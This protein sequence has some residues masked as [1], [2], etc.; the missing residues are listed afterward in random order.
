MWFARW[1]LIK[2][3]GSTPVTQR[4]FSEVVALP[5]SSALCHQPTSA[6]YPTGAAL[7]PR[8]GGLPRTSGFDTSAGMEVLN[9]MTKI[10]DNLR[11]HSG[12]ACM[13]RRALIYRSLCG[14]RLH[15]ALQGPWTD[16]HRSGAGPRCDDTGRGKRLPHDNPV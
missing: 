9:T 13:A 3:M 5:K 6:N 7:S 15:A 10:M 2:G 16:R 4:R 8:P 14:G 11:T 1:V 12:I